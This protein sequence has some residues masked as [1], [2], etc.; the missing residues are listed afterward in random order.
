MTVAEASSRSELEQDAPATVEPNPARRAS[1][2]RL[3]FDVAT[4]SGFPVVES[5][6]MVRSSY[7]ADKQAAQLVKPGERRLNPDAMAPP[8]SL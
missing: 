6:P 4:E 8:S 1:Y 7:H 2:A 3:I 5:G